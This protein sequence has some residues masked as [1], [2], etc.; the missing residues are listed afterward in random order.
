MAIGSDAVR[1][2][3]SK[4]SPSQS[5]QLCEHFV[6]GT[7]A[8][9]V[10]GLVG[11][12]K[13]TAALF[14]RR[15]REIIAEKVEDDS[16]PVTDEDWV[17][18]YSGGNGKRS[19]LGVAGRPLVFQLLRRGEHT[20]AKVMLGDEP[21][22]TI[23]TRDHPGQFASS[24]DDWNGEA[25]RYLPQATGVEERFRHGMAGRDGAMAM[26]GHGEECFQRVSRQLKTYNGIP[27]RYL[28]LFL[29]EC[30]WRLNYGSHADLLETLMAWIKASGRGAAPDRWS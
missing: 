17:A 6:A 7:S 28:R 13:N 24:V 19:T 5:L 4:L 15:L 16:P 23:P 3:R 22:S 14:Y 2:R 25:G 9:T 1:L 30:E 18:S 11:V 12:N 8:R 20:Y 27:E 29:K 10:A 21:S 26:G